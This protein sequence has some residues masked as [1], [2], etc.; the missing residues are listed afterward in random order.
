M[1]QLFVEGDLSFVNFPT[2][3]K[4]LRFAWISRF[5]DFWLTLETHGKQSP[6]I[7]SPQ[8]W[9]TVPSQMYLQC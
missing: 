6:I 4:S 7:L 2:L 9:V 1:Y 8:W 5:L 3:V